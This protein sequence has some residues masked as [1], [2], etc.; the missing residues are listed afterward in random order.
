MVILGY[1]VWQTRFGGDAAAVGRTVRV[2]DVPAIVIGV[3]PA[4]FKYPFLS[5]VWQPLALWPGAAIA[6]RDSR[7]RFGLA[8]EIGLCACRCLL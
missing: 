7:N 3:M 1:E 5:E 4:G 8:A 6:R 2:N